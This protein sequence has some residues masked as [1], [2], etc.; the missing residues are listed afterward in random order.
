MFQ[1]QHFFI[2]SSK[3]VE[4]RELHYTSISMLGYF[5]E[6]EKTIKANTGSRGNVKKNALNDYIKFPN[7]FIGKFNMF[8]SATDNWTLYADRF[9][10]C[11][12]VNLCILGGGVPVLLS[13]M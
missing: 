7:D 3:T 12:E 1:E 9:E 2:T 6:V 4:R 8:D 10:E 13:V 5:R 11:F